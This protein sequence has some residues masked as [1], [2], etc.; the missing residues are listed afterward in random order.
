RRLLD[1][2]HLCFPY[3]PQH[4]TDPLSIR[5]CAQ[6]LPPV[7]SCSFFN[8]RSGRS[9]PPV[10]ALS[11]S[12]QIVFLQTSYY[13]RSQFP[14]RWPLTVPAPRQTP[15]PHPRLRDCSKTQL[16][17][18]AIPSAAAPLTPALPTQ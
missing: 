15:P 14:A 10:R 8:N 1:I 9:S 3:F 5:A 6:C 2:S 12:P 7:I 11:P 16:S 18:P 13:P 4:S 17:P